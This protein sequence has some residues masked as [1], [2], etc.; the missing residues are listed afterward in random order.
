MPARTAIERLSSPALGSAAERERHDL[1]DCLS[2][3]LLLDL[4]CVNRRLAKARADDVVAWASR[5]FGE[6]LVLSTSFGIQSA[7]MLHLVGHAAPHVPVVWVDTGYLPPETY[8]YADELTRRLDLNV[9]V[10]QSPVSPARMEA[11]HGRLWESED[12]DAYERY[13]QLRKVEPM[14]R[15]LRDLGGTAWLS[16]VRAQQTD[17][18]AGLQVVGRQNGRYKV[19]P[20]LAWSSKDVFDYMKAHD[21]PQHPLFEQGYG[22]VGDWHSSRA[23]HADDGHERDTRFQGR[24]QECGIHLDLDDDEA[25]SLD[26]SRL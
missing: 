26:A 21:L 19:S 12:D 24:R 23:V 14:Q 5:Q 15:A 7:V 20:I 9:H 3:E 6:G 25:A 2:A 13:D 22:T 16:G 1:S 4:G 10:Y 11:I 18:R 8:R 17:H